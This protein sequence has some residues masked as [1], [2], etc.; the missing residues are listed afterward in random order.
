MVVHRPCERLV[1]DDRDAAFRRD[2]ANARLDRLQPDEIAVELVHDGADAGLLVQR[3]EIDSIFYQPT[4]F[5]L[6]RNKVG[7]PEEF[8]E[9]RIGGGLRY[10]AVEVARCI[11]AGLTESPILPLDET[12]RIMATLDEVRRQIGLRYPFE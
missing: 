4:S 9:S 8:R 10:Q 5:R 11:D 1:L 7:A 12:V 3:I 2:L 6:R